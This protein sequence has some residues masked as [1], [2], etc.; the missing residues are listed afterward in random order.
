MQWGVVLA[1]SA[2]VWVWSTAAALSLLAG[3]AAVAAP[4]AMLALWLTVRGRAGG[5]SMA[6]VMMVGEMLKLGLTLALL[7]MIGVRFKPLLNWLALVAGVLLALKAQW[8]A[9]WM[10]RRY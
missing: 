4:N 8:L 5:G 7:V 1:L 6:L 2:L 9:L 3:G 10:T